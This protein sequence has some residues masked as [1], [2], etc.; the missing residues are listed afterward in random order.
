MDLYNLV[1]LSGWI[2]AI[3]LALNFMTCLNMPWS[4]TKCLWKGDRPGTDKCDWKGFQPIAYMHSIIVW[5]TIAATI[6]HL[7]VAIAYR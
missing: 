3:S 5:V 1:I 4:K 2:A 6:F 7:I